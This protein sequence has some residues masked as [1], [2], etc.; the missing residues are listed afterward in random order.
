MTKIIEAS[1]SVYFGYRASQGFCLR[2]RLSHAYQLVHEKGKW[3]L[4]DEWRQSLH[5]KE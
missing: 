3:S 1:S 2:L 5:H 4:L